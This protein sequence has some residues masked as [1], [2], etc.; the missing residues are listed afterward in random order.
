MKTKGFYAGT[1]DPPTLGHVHVL[2]Q[3]LMLFDQ[4]VVGIGVNPAKK[5]S[6]MFTPEERAEMI[7]Y[8]YDF[9]DDKERFQIIIYEGEFLVHRAMSEY[10]THIIRGI[11]NGR[12]LEEEMT[13]HDLNGQIAQTFR[14]YI[15]RPS[16]VFIPTPSHLAHVSSSM[17][18]SLIG[19][20]DW[21]HQLRR[22]LP[23]ASVDAVMR[24]YDAP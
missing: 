6:T 2:D 8:T 7:R 9:L 19:F 10:C 4:V 17:V 5:G 23:N 12:D 11:R 24:K 14:N 20:G 1:F 3:A 18:K 22:F 21:K 16:T 15:T 13:M